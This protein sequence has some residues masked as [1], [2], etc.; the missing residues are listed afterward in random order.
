M[1]V[2]PRGQ[3]KVFFVTVGVL[4]LCALALTWIFGQF[5]GW[6][7]M[8]ILGVCLLVISLPSACLLTIWKMKKPALVFWVLAVVAALWVLYDFRILRF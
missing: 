8:R 6:S 4:L 7:L 2:I 3:P 1:G 5:A